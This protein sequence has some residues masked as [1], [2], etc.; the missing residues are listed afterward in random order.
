[1]RLENRNKDLVLS[2]LTEMW[3]SNHSWQEVRS[4]SNELRFAVIWECT[5]CDTRM[6]Y[7]VLGTQIAQARLVLKD[8]ST[9][10]FFSLEKNGK[11]GITQNLD[12]TEVA[13]YANCQ[14]CLVRS[15][16]E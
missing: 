11:G 7:M 16:I 6:A 10:T 3:K 14:E 4:H 5:Q 2:E 8:F 12:L 13:P 1:M 15:I 9:I